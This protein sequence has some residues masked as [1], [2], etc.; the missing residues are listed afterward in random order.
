MTDPSLAASKRGATSARVRFL[1]SS[2]CEPFLAHSWPY[3]YRNTQRTERVS[4]IACKTFHRQPSYYQNM[5]IENQ[6]N[7]YSAPTDAAKLLT[8][9]EKIVLIIW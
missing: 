7:L 5:T 2:K 9:N 6:E 1:R 3:E 8:K 4:G